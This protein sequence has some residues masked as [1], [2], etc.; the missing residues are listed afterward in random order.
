MT[1][2]SLLFVSPILGASVCP[3]LLLFYWILEELLIYQ[4]VQLYLIELMDSWI[5]GFLLS[6]PETSILL[7]FIS[8][9]LLVCP[10]FEQHYKSVQ[11]SEETEALAF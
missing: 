4:S 9:L 10:G 5:P 2:C 8:L 1:P 11:Q 6:E 3:V 7:C